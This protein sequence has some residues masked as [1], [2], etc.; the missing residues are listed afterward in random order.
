MIFKL[1]SVSI[2]SGIALTGIA[3]KADAGKGE[4]DSNLVN[5]I[6]IKAHGNLNIEQRGAGNSALVDQGGK[7][8]TGN[9]NQKLTTISNGI[10]NILYSL[11]GDSSS[12]SGNAT[13][14][15]QSG[16]GNT[17]VIRQSGNGNR[18]NITQSPAK[19]EGE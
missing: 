4:I 17:V 13:N 2:F 7:K 10:N 14:V 18:V 19:K 12:I 6:D 1:L 15:K 8:S 5:K 16:S 11:S 3:Q 9:S